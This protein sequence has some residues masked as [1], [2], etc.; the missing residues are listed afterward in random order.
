MGKVVE[1]VG[2]SL[3]VSSSGKVYHFLIMY[4]MVL[5]VLILRS[6]E[7][8][9]R[10]QVVVYSAVGRSIQVVDFPVDGTVQKGCYYLFIRRYHYMSQYITWFAT[11]DVFY[12]LFSFTQNI[13]QF[14]FI[15]AWE[16]EKLSV[17]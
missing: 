13:W 3:D 6:L 14:F 5:M 8:A 15:K 11:N 1:E 7:K 4:L 10:D 9:W 16:L 12:D 17:M 2:E